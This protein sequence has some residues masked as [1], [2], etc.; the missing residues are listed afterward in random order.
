VDKVS[1]RM[2]SREPTASARMIS[3][4][5]PLGG[6]AQLGASDRDDSLLKPSG[7]PLMALLVGAPPPPPAS[8]PPKKRSSSR[9][10]RTQHPSSPAATMSSAQTLSIKN[11][12]SRASEVSSPTA[13]RQEI[14]STIEDRLRKSREMYQQPVVQRSQSQQE[15]PKLVSKVSKFLAE[16]PTREKPLS[17]T[18]LNT[19][20]RSTRSVKK[21]ELQSTEAAAPSRSKTPQSKRRKQTPQRSERTPTREKPKAARSKTPQGKSRVAGG[22]VEKSPKKGFFRKLFKKKPKSDAST[23]AASEMKTVKT[24][25]RSREDRI[26]RKVRAELQASM[27][28]KTT[29]VQSSTVPVN[30]WHPQQKTALPTVKSGDGRAHDFYFS[31]DD[32][33]ALTIPTVSAH[34]RNQRHVQPARS[35]ELLSDPIGQF[36]HPEGVTI[37][38][39]P[40]P[41]VD[42]F[43]AAF[44]DGQDAP[45]SIDHISAAFDNGNTFA[46]PGEDPFK[47]V[48]RTRDLAPM[49]DAKDPLPTTSDRF[50]RPSLDAFESTFAKSQMEPSP[51]GF[52]TLELAQDPVGASAID[53]HAPDPPLALD[54]EMSFLSVSSLGNHLKSEDSREASSASADERAESHESSS[55]RLPPSPPH[56]PPTEKIRV[57]SLVDLENTA[58][59]DEEP[60][61]SVRPEPSDTGSAVKKTPALSFAHRFKKRISTPRGRAKNDRAGDTNTSLLHSTVNPASDESSM[62][63][64]MDTD[65]SCG[66][67]PVDTDTSSD[68]ATVKSDEKSPGQRSPVTSTLLKRTSRMLSAR[69]A[70]RMNTKA[71]SYVRTV[72]KQSPSHNEGVHVKTSDLDA[73][74]TPNGKAGTKASV[75]S[76]PRSEPS[77]GASSTQRMHK[78][79]SKRDKFRERKTEKGK[80]QAHSL[81][82]RSS[83]GGNQRK[84]VECVASPRRLSSTKVD[85]FSVGVSFLRKKRDDEIASGKKQR[86]IPVEKEVKVATVQSYFSPM[87]DLEPKDPIQRAGRRLLAKAAVPI[88]ACARRF[89]AQRQAVDRMWAILEIQSCFRRWKSE[90]SLLAYRKAAVCLQRHARGKQTRGELSQLNVAAIDVQRV[91]RGYLASIHTF[92][93]VYKIILVQARA[94]GNSTRR[95]A[96]T[97]REKIFLD[98]MATK[99]QARVRGNAIRTVARE[100][101]EVRETVAA[102]FLQASWRRLFAQRNAHTMKLQLRASTSIQ[103]WWRCYSARQQFQMLVVCV[104]IAQSAIRRWKT[105]SSYLELRDAVQI[106]AATKI[107]CAWRGFQGYTDYIFSL[108]DVIV[109]QRTAR[110]WLAKRRAVE[111]RR[112]RSAV[113]IQKHFRRFSSQMTL[114][115]S[116]VHIIMVQVRDKTILLFT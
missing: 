55:D 84:S 22:A 71:V 38:E 8:P 51:R 80:K 70:A 73:K 44:F 111:L 4:R 18:S 15:N 63:T 56:S 58:A 6:T 83:N 49:P 99:I 20:Q 69:T 10:Q 95:E 105:R 45:S 2:A 37:K 48:M 96:A 1:G 116:L 61:I 114:L 66:K 109:V 13:R 78:F 17:P 106:R 9:R 90:A 26:D 103:T 5:D 86:C 19:S 29:E 93:A 50:F 60:E 77:P 112:E 41:S 52:Q 53:E 82:S 42:P 113:L 46:P 28:R 92:D 79:V 89:L 108:V 36:Y 101:K 104:I 23:V 81:R 100:E 75:S 97:I 72:N 88:Q 7:T 59:S 102:T 107:Q 16:T 14:A 25:D 74:T 21:V 85:A 98:V 3:G 94:R 68:Q 11:S 32:V 40:S 57:E 33:S 43:T 30:G 110:V 91:V 31:Q 54:N 65:S 12:F 47:S 87:K 62:S 35:L 34:S 39:E 115:F 76:T 27:L 64:T 24:E 67:D